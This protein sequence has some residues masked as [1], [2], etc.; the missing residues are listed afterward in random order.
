MESFTYLFYLFLPEILN[1]V[2]F[3]KFSRK[4]F[5]LLF[6]LLLFRDSESEESDSE[7]KI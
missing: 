6:H 5:Y 3:I 2:C 1:K 4:L 7:E